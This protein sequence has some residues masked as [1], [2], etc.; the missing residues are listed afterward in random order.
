M[1]Y[2]DQNILT[3]VMEVITGEYEGLDYDEVEPT[4]EAIKTEVIKR[5]MMSLKNDY[6]NN[7]VKWVDYMWPKGER[8]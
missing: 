8:E 2:T 7:M 6:L 1:R 4:Y 3:E 5:M